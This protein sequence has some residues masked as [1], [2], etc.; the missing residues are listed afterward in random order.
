MFFSRRIYR[1]EEVRQKRRRDGGREG[2]TKEWRRG[3]KSERVLLSEL[4]FLL[5][6]LRESFEKESKSVCH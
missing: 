2:V 1:E 4:F 5:V 6:P 3:L